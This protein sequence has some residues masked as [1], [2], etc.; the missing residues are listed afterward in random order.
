[1]F[2]VLKLANLGKTYYRNDDIL[3]ISS[4]RVHFI[5][6]ARTRHFLEQMSLNSFRSLGLHR[7]NARHRSALRLL[8]KSSDPYLS[9]QNVAVSIIH[10]RLHIIWLVLPVRVSVTERNDCRWLIYFI[11][12]LWWN[13][14]KTQLEGGMH[15]GTS[16]LYLPG[17][18]K[19][20]EKRLIIAINQSTSETW[21]FLSQW[22]SHQVSPH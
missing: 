3:W 19:F 4:G 14:N 21:K 13:S 15:I 9:F 8:F 2:T 7:N 22:P 18:N 1:M 6:S 20:R 11:C 5:W 16:V 10:R 12:V 17:P